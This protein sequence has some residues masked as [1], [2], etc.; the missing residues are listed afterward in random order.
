M[1]YYQLLIQMAQISMAD[2]TARF[3]AG[4]RK[5]VDEIATKHN[6]EMRAQFAEIHA[7]ISKVEAS[8]QVLMTAKESKSR[9]VKESSASS[10]P[11]PELAEGKKLGANI[12][13]HF[14]QE[15]VED[16]EF[17]T[18]CQAAPG[19]TEAVNASRESGTL[20]KLIGKEKEPAYMKTE[21]TVVYNHLS[22][23]KDASFVEFE[24]VYREQ[25]KAAKAKAKAV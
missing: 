10:A 14:Q 3:E 16:A 4:V 19:S 8:I 11:V 15:Y 2:L 6:E 17:R 23:V 13:T 12:K 20:K 21:A 5:I 1:L 25:S 7:R 18:K 9:T 24:R 22:T